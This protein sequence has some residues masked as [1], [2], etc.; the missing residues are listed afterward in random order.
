MPADDVIRQL[1]S[2]PS[3]TYS[4]PRSLGLVPMD[5]M[6]PSLGRTCLSLAGSHLPLV[7]LRVTPVCPSTPRNAYTGTAQVAFTKG[8]LEIG[9]GWGGARHVHGTVPSKNGSQARPGLAAQ[10]AR[11][12]CLAQLKS[13]PPLHPPLALLPPQTWPSRVLCQAGHPDSMAWVGAVSRDIK[14]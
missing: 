3:E 13:S 5:S 9:K 2:A 1:L 8:W 11:W 4:N 7:W 10:Q 12:R 14:S 6:V